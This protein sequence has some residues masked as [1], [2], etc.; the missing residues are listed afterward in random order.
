MADERNW[1]SDQLHVLLGY[2]V[3]AVVSFVAGLGAC[4]RCISS[5]AV[6]VLV[7]SVCHAGCPNSC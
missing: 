1:I 2:S 3:P 7:R 5:L 6:L 4:V